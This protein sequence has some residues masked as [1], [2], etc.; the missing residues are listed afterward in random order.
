MWSISFLGIVPDIDGPS[1]LEDLPRQ[2][3]AP[4]FLPEH[5][6][7]RDFVVGQLDLDEV[8]GDARGCDGLGDDDMTTKFCPRKTRYSFVSH[9]V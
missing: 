9:D 6:N 5:V 7:C 2:T 3:E 8:F 1:G 4:I